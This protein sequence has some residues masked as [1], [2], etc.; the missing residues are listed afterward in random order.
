MYVAFRA[1]GRPCPSEPEAEEQH[2]VML[3]EPAMAA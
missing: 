1:L 2:D 3:D